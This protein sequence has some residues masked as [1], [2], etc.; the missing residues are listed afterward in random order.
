MDAKYLSR[1]AKAACKALHMTPREF[2]PVNSNMGAMAS[3][4]D[5]PEYPVLRVWNSRREV[6]LT[7][8]DLAYANMY[9]Q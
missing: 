7:N 8:H 3:G 9:L 1:E 4:P 6:T 2:E 5:D